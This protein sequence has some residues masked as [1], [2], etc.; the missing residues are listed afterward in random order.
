MAAQM[1]GFDEDCFR[2]SRY[3][4]NSSDDDDEYDEYDD[5]VNGFSPSDVDDLM[6]QGISPFDSDAS[7]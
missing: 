3:T 7:M 1:L 5:Y 2:D 6:C 4:F